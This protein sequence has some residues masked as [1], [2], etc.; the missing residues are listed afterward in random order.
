MSEG[1]KNKQCQICKGYLFEEDDVVICPTCGAPHHRDCWNTVGHC[2]VEEFHGTDKQYDKIDLTSDGHGDETAKDNN[3]HICPRCRRM[4]HAK[5]AEF[6]PYCGQPY[7]NN[8]NHA[9]AGGFV[10]SIPMFDPYGGLPKDTTIDGV[11]VENIANFVGS[12][13]A[14]YI[15]KFSSLSKNKKGSWNWAAFL[16]PAGWCFARKM[17]PQGILY[18]VL[19]V[20]STLCAIPLNETYQDLLVDNTNLNYME[21]FQFIESNIGSFSLISIILAFIGT[22]L[23]LLPRIFCG[24]LGDWHYKNFCIEKIKKILEDP[25]ID[26]KESTL[27]QKGNISIWLLGLAYIAVQFLPS[28]IYSLL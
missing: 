24:R 13:S 1:T 18:L 12:N 8:I 6:C 17:I 5:D 3:T 25:E 20:A 11:T 14:R 22:A 23:L 21:M 26:D 4:S 7:N 2:G 10:N 28:I 16:F 15:N 9:G 19:Q 27:R